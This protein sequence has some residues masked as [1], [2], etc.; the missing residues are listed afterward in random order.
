MFNEPRPIRQYLLLDRCISP[1]SN[2]DQIKWI[3]VSD[4][5][6]FPWESAFTG[7]DVTQPCCPA[8]ANNEVHIT[9]DILLA[10]Q[11]QYAAT[12]DER[13]LHAEGCAVIQRTAEFLAS[14]VQLDTATGLYDIRGKENEPITLVAL[15]LWSILLSNVLQTLWAQTKITRK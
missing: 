8:V 4:L 15:S 6:R 2:Y 7:R 13:W 12:W 3:I 1:D 11:Q 10:F 5:H 14:R 9:A